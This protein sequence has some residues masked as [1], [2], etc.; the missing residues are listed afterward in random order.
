MYLDGA[1]HPLPPIAAS[2][3]THPLVELTRAAEVQDLDGRPFGVAEHDVL[4]LEVAVDDLQLGRG[5]EAQRRAQ[6]LRELPGERERDAAELGVSQQVEQ[7]VGEQL[8]H[9]AQVVPPHE[10]VPQPHWG[11]THTAGRIW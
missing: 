7:V 9:Q 4:R 1:G 8:E 3:P 10:V 6:L 2:A 5:Q 11:H